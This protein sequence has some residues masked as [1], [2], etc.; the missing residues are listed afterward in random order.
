MALAIVALGVGNASLFWIGAIGFLVSAFLVGAL[1][2]CVAKIKGEVADLAI[3]AHAHSIEAHEAR[4]LDAA[5]LCKRGFACFTQGDYPQAIAFFDAALRKDPALPDAHVARVNA[6]G[7]LGQWH[8]VIAEYTEVIRKDPAHALAYCARATARNG[9]GRWDLALPDAEAAIRLA[10]ELYLGYDARGYALVQRGSFHPILKWI[11]IA[12]AI[13]TFGFL[14]RDRF[15]WKTP[16][17][18]QSDFERAV[19][20]FSEAIRLNPA[21]WDCYQGRAMAHRALGDQLQ[22]TLDEAKMREGLA[23]G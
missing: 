15:A 16:T 2:A 1:G 17:G 9:M 19:A 13:V 5:H 14:R 11:G 18:T 22:A 12:W 7:A 3:A 6:H 23:R 4:V 10:P 21:A 20:D 8:R